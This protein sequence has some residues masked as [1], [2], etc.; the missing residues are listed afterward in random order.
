[1]LKSLAA[2]VV[3]SLFSLMLATVIGAAYLVHQ[4]DAKLNQPLQLSEVTEWRLPEGYSVNRVA[5][6]W[7]GRGWVETSFWIK[8]AVKLDPTLA[9]IKA[10]TYDLDPSQSLKQTLAML[11]S[12]DQKTFRITLVEGETVAQVLERIEAH[13]QLQRTVT[14]PQ[15]LAAL[16]GFDGANP[17]GMIFPDT[18][19]FHAGDSDRSLLKRAAE[20]LTQ[21]LD[22]A[23]GA[24]QSALPID[25]AYEMLILASIIEKE[26][27][28]G[29]ERPLIG[30][31][32]VNRLN[33][34]MRLQTDPTVIYGMG[35]AY[36]GNIRKQDLRQKTPYNTYRIDGLPP[37]PIAIVGREAL[38][39]AAQP[40]SSHYY[41]FV[42]RG[43]GSHQFS[44]TLQQHNRAVNRYIRKR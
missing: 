19:Q 29:S 1:M 17:E 9:H 2:K 3:L 22:R 5:N 12:G 28:L 44:E 39:A 4:L 15:Q 16:I 24:R 25:S 41:Y 42:A 40:A 23:W 35:D 14:S 32:F 30:S 20:R 6:N 34:R 11:V 18:Y 7:S 27:G 38:M 13:P 31:V 33:K 37:T 8:L 43:D 36:Q 10:G 21:E 26:T